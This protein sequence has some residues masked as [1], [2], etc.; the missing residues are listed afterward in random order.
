MKRSVAEAVALGLAAF[1]AGYI[2]AL[3]RAPNAA[4]DPSGR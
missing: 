4:N 1:G 3:R 2:A